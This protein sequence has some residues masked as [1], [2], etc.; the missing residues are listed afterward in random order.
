M[1]PKYSDWIR[2]FGTFATAPNKK[3]SSVEFQLEAKDVVSTTNGI[4]SQPIHFTDVQFQSGQQ[5]S[6]WIPNTRELMKHL[7]WTNDENENVAL[8]AI[9]EGNQPIIREGLEKR[10]FNVVGRGAETFV[11]PNYFPEDNNI[12]ILPSGIDLT[13]IPKEDFDLLRVSTSYG[14]ML[15]ENE[16]YYKQ[17]DGL[18]R[19]IEAKYAQVV[20][21]EPTTNEAKDRKN[22]EISN[23]ENIVNPLMGNHPLHKRYTREFFVEG[24]RKGEEIKIHA[25]T[26]TATKG[27]EELP[28][29]G[30]RDLDIKGESFPIGRRKFMIAPKGTAMIRIELYKQTERN[31]VTYDRNENYTFTKVRKKMVMLEDVGIGYRGT[32]GFH[33]WTNGRSRI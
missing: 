20:D 12:D 16:Q 3:V 5:L 24:G 22:R 8:P 17:D 13:L 32:A 23:W 27:S 18:Y 19:E 6:G 33:Q 15:P 29:V 7:S 10:W 9:F 31:I 26:R 25:S 21:M 1:I 2:F 28:L 11:I 30:I 14:V 4:D